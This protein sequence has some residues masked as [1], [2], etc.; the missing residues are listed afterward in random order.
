V[1]SGENAPA[2]ITIHAKGVTKLMH[3]IAKMEPSEML[4]LA[5]IVAVT[6]MMLIRI[7]RYMRRQ[8]KSQSVMV[9]TDRPD[10]GERG[11]HLGLPAE[12]MK[13]EVEMHQTARDLSA[14]LDSKMSALGHLIRDADLASARLETALE[15]A[16]GH[17]QPPAQAESLEAT[18]TTD[19]HPDSTPVDGSPGEEAIDQRGHEELYT[20]AD[21][22]FDAREIAR[23][24]GIPI[25]EVELIL[26]LR[27]DTKK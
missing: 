19:T 21:Y 12:A 27:T 16:S 11:H 13:W 17:L 22:G 14:Q 5:V 1:V 3:L 18:E 9:R 24:L 4:L 25:G 23:R 20:L 6:S 10:R 15:A 2:Q 8:K 7:R 26:R